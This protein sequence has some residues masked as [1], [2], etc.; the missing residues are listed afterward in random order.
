MIHACRRRCAAAGAGR[1]FLIG[2]ALLSSR[3]VRF[4]AARGARR[5]REL[6]LSA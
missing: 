6:G 3:V 2:G 1:S 5:W 4:M